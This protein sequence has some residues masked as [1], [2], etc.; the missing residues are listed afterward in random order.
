MAALG[1]LIVLAS[2]WAARILHVR[3]LS[4]Q[5]QAARVIATVGIAFIATQFLF[6]I[7]GLLHPVRGYMVGVVYSLT[8]LVGWMAW[9][10][11]TPRVE[12]WV[13]LRDDELEALGPDAPE[14]YQDNEPPQPA[15]G[16]P[17]AG[18][19][20]FVLLVAFSGFL[21]DGAVGDALHFVASAR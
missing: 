18:L 5:P 7:L 9:Q 21:S 14:Q 16:T 3:A 17:V 10:T 1:V 8:V 20:V 15:K 2:A 12:T 6:G 11:F 13:P 19:S 4:K